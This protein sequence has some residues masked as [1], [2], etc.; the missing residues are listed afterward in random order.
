MNMNQ[1]STHLPKIMLVGL[2]VRTTNKAEAETST[3]KIPSLVQKFFVE[4]V[5]SKINNRA[6]AGVTYIVFTEYENDFMGEYTCFIGEE[7]SEF[8]ELCEGF[9]SLTIAAQ[10]YAKFTN[11]PGELPNV[12]LDVWRRV[13]QMTPLELGGKRSYLADFEVYDERAQDPKNIVLD[14]YV[15]VKKNETL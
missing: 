4:S 15:G 9:S 6:R 2:F 13:W 10:D 11:G 1:I 12:S 8:L 3:A 14:I 7:V 5:S